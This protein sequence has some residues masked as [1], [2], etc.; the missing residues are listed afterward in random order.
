MWNRIWNVRHVYGY[1]II[2]NKIRLIPL[3]IQDRLK[4]Y[5]AATLDGYKIERLLTTTRKE[6]LS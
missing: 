4:P 5:L 6:K 1:V 3:P 2:T